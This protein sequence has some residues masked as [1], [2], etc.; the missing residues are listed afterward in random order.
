MWF[1]AMIGVA[2]LMFAVTGCIPSKPPADQAEPAAE[3]PEPQ[4]SV[5]PAEIGGAAGTSAKSPETPAAS[6]DSKLVLDMENG[7]E[8]NTGVQ[9]V[10]ME[11]GKGYSL[12]GSLGLTGT[13]TQP[14]PEV[15]EWTLSAE[16][17][18]PSTGFMVGEPYSTFVDNFM[19]GGNKLSVERSTR[20]AL[21][22]IPVR[23]P[24]RS[25]EVK[26]EITKIP[27]TLKI[28]AGKDV[29]FAVLLGA[30]P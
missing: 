19:V 26:K 29:Q 23:L 24:A 27:V 7:P 22:T 18:F 2:C 11:D 15:D 30:M 16:F 21:I 17:A 6:G 5:T 3:V 14:R 10:P 4:V 28:N 12:R 9:V 8:A 13:I 20:M 25:A 1:R